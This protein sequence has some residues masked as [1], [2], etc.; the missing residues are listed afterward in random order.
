MIFSSNPNTEQNTRIWRCWGACNRDDV[1]KC[2]DLLTYFNDFLTAQ[3]T[4]CLWNNKSC[5]KKHWLEA[6]EKRIELIVQVIGSRMIEKQDRHWC[7]S[8]LAHIPNFNLKMVR[9]CRV[10]TTN[11][12]TKRLVSSSGQKQSYNQTQLKSLQQAQHQISSVNTFII[13]NVHWNFFLF[14]SRSSDVEELK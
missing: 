11:N 3:M 4:K 2:S 1:Y 14:C 12:M 7:C 9:N 6:K 8:Y 10:I 5:W 13:R